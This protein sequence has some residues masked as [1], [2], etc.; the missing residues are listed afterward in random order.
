MGTELNEKMDQEDR[1]YEGKAEEVDED[2]IYSVREDDNATDEENE[3]EEV[4]EREKK[5]GKKVEEIVSRF[6]VSAS[7]EIVN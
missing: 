4:K 2:I 5:F 6:F 3:E 1:D 7:F